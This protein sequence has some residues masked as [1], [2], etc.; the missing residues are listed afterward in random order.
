MKREVVL[1]IIIGFSLGLIITFGVWRANKALKETA[2]KQQLPL[3]QE[4]QPELPPST[5]TP[6]TILDLE[7][8]SPEDNFLSNKEKIDVS[9]KTFPKATV[10]ILYEEGEKIIES[11]EEGKFT[12]EITLVGGANEITI[13][14]YD[15]EGNEISK[16]LNVVYSTA[17]I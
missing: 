10:V 14:A 11:D 9:G 1:A 4:K 8:T 13:S 16:T 7:I 5:P 6:Q 3:S 12:S 17:E 15:K 2:P